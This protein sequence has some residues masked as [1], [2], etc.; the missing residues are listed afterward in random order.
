MKFVFGKLNQRL[1]KLRHTYIFEDSCKNSEIYDGEFLAYL[2]EVSKQYKKK[3]NPENVMIGGKKPSN[4]RLAE[5][6]ME[7]RI[8]TDLKM[9]IQNQTELEINLP[10]INSLQ[11]SKQNMR[12]KMPYSVYMK[13]KKSA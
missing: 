7:E 2:E 5:L 9:F 12:K 10:R 8:M 13:K 4:L 6:T 1:T 3:K 11:I